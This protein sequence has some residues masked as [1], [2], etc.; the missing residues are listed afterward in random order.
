LQDLTLDSSD[1]SGV[2]LTA[3][4]LTDSHVS[5]ADIQPIFDA[6]SAQ[7]TAL[8]ITQ[9]LSLNYSDGSPD[10]SPD[11]AAPSAPS[12][13]PPSNPAPASGTQS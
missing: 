4:L 3:T 10:S 1:D 7:F 5:S 8:N 13:S 6:L 2:F 9:A 12:S 11:S